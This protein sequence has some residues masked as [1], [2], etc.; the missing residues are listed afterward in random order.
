MFR[1]SCKYT[2][3]QDFNFLTVL[4]IWRCIKC[5]LS[6]S[7]SFAVLHEQNLIWIF[8]FKR[9]NN[10]NMRY[11]FDFLQF[12]A[13]AEDLDWSCPYFAGNLLLLTVRLAVQPCLSRPAWMAPWNLFK[14]RRPKTQLKPFHPQV[15][16]KGPWLDQFKL[17]CQ[18]PH[19]MTRCQDKQTALSRCSE[20][21]SW[22]SVI[23]FNTWTPATVSSWPVQPYQ[24]KN[25]VLPWLSLAW[26]STTKSAIIPVPKITIHF[27]YRKV[28]CLE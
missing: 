7:D 8:E 18:H 3:I 5:C 25:M 26:L 28:P 21:S 20:A 6:A 14:K 9:K 19:V 11:N 4:L 17:T 10:N 2:L 23:N 16:E 27:Q 15:A 22:D 13:D 1:V 24:C 12:S